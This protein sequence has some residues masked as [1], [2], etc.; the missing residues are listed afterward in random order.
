MDRR[1]RRNH[2]DRRRDL[3]RVELVPLSGDGAL[4]YTHSG[5]RYLLGYAENFFGIWDR[6][7]GETPVA[8]FP[9]TDDGWKQAWTQFNAWEPYSAEVGIG[10]SR[11]EPAAPAPDR[12]AFGAPSPRPSPV[13]PAW[14]LAPILFGLLGG[15]VAFL[16]NRDRDARTARTMLIVGASITIVLTFLYYAGGPQ[17]S[18]LHP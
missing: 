17:T 9:R 8:R 7:A 5:S 12:G 16:V 6:S 14:W 10:P 13:S 1:G 11:S 3:E 4:Q 2:R 15:L 18:Q